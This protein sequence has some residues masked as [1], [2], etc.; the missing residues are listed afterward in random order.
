MGGLLSIGAEQA[1]LTD[2]LGHIPDHKINRLDE[3]LP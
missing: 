2:A 1:W 3:L